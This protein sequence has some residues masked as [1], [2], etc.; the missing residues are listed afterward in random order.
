MD[1]VDTSN[2]PGGRT[3]RP[4]DRKAQLAAV[5]AELF[6]ARGYHEVGITDIAAAAGV[7]GPALYRHFS[8]KQAILAHVV[9]SGIDE[10]IAT[11]QRAL[12]DA[13]KPAPEQVDAL[14]DRLAAMSV[15]HRD[16]A[17]LWRWERRNLSPEHQRE[18]RR[19][20]SVLIGSWSATLRT[21]RPELAE[22]DADL[23]CWAALSVFGST[24]VHSTRIAKRRYTKLLIACARAVLHTTLPT[25]PRPTATQE[26][27]RESVFLRTTRKDELITAASKLFQDRGFHDVS[28]EDIGSATGI[29]G[30]SVYRHFPSKAALFMAAAQRIAQRLEFGRLAVA[31][32]ATSEADVL[33]GF[34]ASYIETMASSA[35]L[36]TAS[37][38]VSALSNADRAELKRV[39]RDYVAEW[40]HLLRAVRPTLGAAEARVVV[41]MALTI[42]NDVIHSGRLAGRPN[43]HAEL[44]TIM[45]VALGLPA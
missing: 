13:D 33:H 18:V 37:S 14:L 2:A 12:D 29:S 45:A 1:T 43:L 17:S 6:C 41:H 30:P 21:L 23:L 5:A 39:Q 15:D 31:R 44:A 34:V 3:R 20:S 11:T 19:R 10:L 8:D 27:A 9:L 38:Q 7:T 26:T 24:A 42:A 28:M 32:T 4:W 40:T 25:E 35:D 36:M 22:R 16:V